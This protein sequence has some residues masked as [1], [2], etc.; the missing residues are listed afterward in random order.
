[1]PFDNAGFMLRDLR[2]G[3]RILMQAKGWTTV[4]VL[5]LAV[6]IGANAA[7]FTAVNSL[8]LKELPVRDPDS[9]VRLR[10][11]GDND[12]ARDNS[13]YGYAAPTAAGAQVRTTYSYPMFEQLKSSAPTLIDLAA[14]RPGGVSEGAS[15]RAEPSG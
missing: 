8:L 4:V 15:R 1:M 14:S 13:G 10:W 5:S 9:L 12:L 11:T 2:H 3:F 7:I 6:G